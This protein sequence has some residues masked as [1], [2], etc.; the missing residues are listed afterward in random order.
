M[1]E[2]MNEGINEQV[3]C[4]ARIRGE[5]LPAKTLSQIVLAENAG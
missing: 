4:C 1:N 3:N 5:C 2:Q